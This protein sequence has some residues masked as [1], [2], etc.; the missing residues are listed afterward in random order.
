[1]LAASY[2]PTDA[3]VIL[4]ARRPNHERAV[5]NNLYG[6][7]AHGVEVIVPEYPAIAPI[8]LEDPCGWTVPDIRL[9]AVSAI[10]REVQSSGEARARGKTGREAY[11]RRYAWD[12][13]EERFLQIV[14]A[15][16]EG[17]VV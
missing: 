2:A 4:L 8:V 6:Y 9:E 10:L 5:P 1:V 16:T 14:R 17:H 15:V 11:V 12:R 3:A 13:Q 7:M